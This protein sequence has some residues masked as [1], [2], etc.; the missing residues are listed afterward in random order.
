MG[1]DIK[2]HKRRKKINKGNICFYGF[3]TIIFLAFAMCV[4]NTISVITIKTDLKERNT[5]IEFLKTQIVSM[6]DEYEKNKVISREF[7]EFMELQDEFNRKLVE[8]LS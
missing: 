3:M 6:Q 5:E 8:K 2:I 4:F 7:S 1:Q